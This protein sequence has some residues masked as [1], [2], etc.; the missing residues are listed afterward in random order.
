VCGDKM[1]GFQNQRRISKLKLIQLFTE[2]PDMP[3]EKIVGLM[4]ATTGISHSKLRTY[5]EELKTE[6]RI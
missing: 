5:I 1:Q 6:G 2:N 4:S 3:E